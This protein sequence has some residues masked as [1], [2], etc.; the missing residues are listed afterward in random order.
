MKKQS[1]AVKGSQSIFNF[2]I[3]WIHLSETYS[4]TDTIKPTNGSTPVSII[5][6]TEINKKLL[7]QK[8]I[9]LLTKTHT[10][11]PFTKNRTKSVHTPT[12]E[13]IQRIIRELDRLKQY[14]HKGFVKFQIK[15]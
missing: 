15:D 13:T 1:I 3:N 14:A 10:T 5:S 12:F 2:V 11:K 7:A 8:L 6:D 9:A 4:E